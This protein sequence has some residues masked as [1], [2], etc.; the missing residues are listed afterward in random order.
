[1][2]SPAVREAAAAQDLNHREPAFAELFPEVRARLSALSGG[3]HTAYVLGGSG[4]AAMEAMVTSCVVQGPVLIVANGYYGERLEAIFAIHGIPHKTLAFDWTSPWDLG[5]VES[6]LARGGYEAVLATHHETTTGRL[7]P[8]H[9]L[10]GIARTHG[11]RVLVDAMSS[12][13]ADPLEFGQLD[14]VCASSNKCLHGLAGVSFV[15]ARDSLPEVPRRTYYLHL[16]MYAG[17]NPPLTPPVPMLM[18]LRQALREFDAEGG[19]PARGSRYARQ[20]A[21]LRSGLR[22]LGLDTL[23][24]DDESSC[25]LSVASVPHGW[26][27]EAWLAANYAQGYALYHCKGPLRDGYFQVSTM[28][29]VTDAMV[30][31]WLS[32]AARL[33]EHGP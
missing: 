13:G 26:S 23:V 20:A 7:N 17:E 11:V 31:D 15:L 33:I 21:C 30:S 9:T 14:A 19:Q 6:E 24:P 22:A 27:A 12:L 4:T 3:S 10:A 16:P 1:M 25:A 8:V 5:A 32:L 2:T 18:A 29:E 28:G